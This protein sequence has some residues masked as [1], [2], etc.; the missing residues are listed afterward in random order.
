MPAVPV[1]IG[2]GG[3]GGGRRGSHPRGRGVS[4][5]RRVAGERRERALSRAEGGGCE[6]RGGPRAKFLVLFIALRSSHRDG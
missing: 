6:G 5:A 2:G 1:E 4:A 3:D